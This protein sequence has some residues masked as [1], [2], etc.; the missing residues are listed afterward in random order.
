MSDCR[1]N[2]VHLIPE[3]PAALPE[4]LQ[5]IRDADLIVIGPG[6]LYTS[7]IPNLLVEGISEEIAASP[8]IKMYV[9]NVMTQ[10]GETE[11]YTASDHIKELFDHAGAKL[12]DV[13]LANSVPAPD[14]L[15]ER[16]GAEGAS[17]IFA[18]KCEIEKTG[19]RGV[20]IA[21]GQF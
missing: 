5:A 14:Y 11:G 21:S 4:S 2:Q 12:F 10:V 9:C 20:R 15:L 18:D 8:A 6:S 19:G 17:Q 16:Y 13:C 7:L 1:I 3:N